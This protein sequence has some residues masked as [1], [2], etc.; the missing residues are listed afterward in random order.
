MI[1]ITG[2]VILPRSIALPDQVRNDVRDLSP[3][4]PV[5]RIFKAEDVRRGRWDKGSHAKARRR[6][7]EIIL[8]KASKWGRSE[9][10]TSE[11]QSRMRISYAGLR[12]KKTKIHR[13][14]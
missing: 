4:P 1:L 3:Q 11:L 8:Y 9:E 6:E 14:T 12:S 10:H 5:K 13:N 2:H 7:E